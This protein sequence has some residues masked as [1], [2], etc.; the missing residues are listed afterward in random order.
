MQAVGVA[1]ALHLAPGE[2]VDDDDLIGLDD[3][4]DVAGEQGVCGPHALLHMVDDGHVED[5]VEV[6]LGQHPGLAQ[7]VLDLL[8]PGLRQGDGLELFLFLVG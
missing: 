3:V 1:A 6:T 5:V 8:G 4:V 7:A 2:L